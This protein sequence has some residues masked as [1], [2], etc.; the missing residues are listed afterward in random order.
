[1]Y[2]LYLNIVFRDHDDLL[3]HE[4]DDLVGNLFPDVANDIY[5][6]ENNTNDPEATTIQENPDLL[7]PHGTSWSVVQD[8]ISI[9]PAANHLYT[10]QASFN[11]HVQ[12]PPDPRNPQIE[13][14]FY[15]LFPMKFVDE[16]IVPCTNTNLK[17]N[18]RS[19]TSKGEFLKFLGITLAM[20]L[21]PIYGGIETYW[22]SCTA[23]DSTMI[24]R[25][26][27]ARFGMS[28]SRFEC[29]RKALALNIPPA[30]PA[31]ESLLRQSDPWWRVSKFIAAFNANREAT[32]TPGQTL[33]VDELMS[34][35]TGIDSEYDFDALPHSSYEQRKPVPKGTEMK[36]MCDGDSGIMLRVEVLEGKERMKQKEFWRE[37]GTSTACV[38]RMGRAYAGSGRVMCHDAWFT[39]MKCCIANYNINGL[40]TQGI[41]KG[42]HKGFPRQYLIDWWES[43]RNNNPTLRRPVGEWISLYCLHDE[44]G[45]PTPTPVIACGWNDL[46]LKCIIATCGTTVKDP[47]DYCRPR[48]RIE[49]IEGEAEQVK[50]EKLI[51]RPKLV[52]QL[53]KHFG[54][55]DFHDRYRQGELHM[56]KSWKT[57]KWPVRVFT[58][59]L[60]IIFTDCFFG[61][62]YYFSKRPVVADMKHL[63]FKHYLDLLAFRLINNPWMTVRKHRKRKR[64][65]PLV[66]EMMPTTHVLD[67]LSQHDYY[68]QKIQSSDKRARLRC[69]ICSSLCSSYC[70]TCTRHSGNSTVPPNNIVALC[71]SPN[72]TCYQSHILQFN[73]F[74]NSN[75][76][77]S[78]N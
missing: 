50:Y 21:D 48:C 31:A 51:Q 16:V 1:M 65:A 40:F 5:G 39:S 36:A 59:I 42:A 44:N 58:S 23:E 20:A 70:V 13:D 73:N 76:S 45:E 14:F 61:Y 57:K 27:E 74:D 68:K 43:G 25:N 32:I 34:G 69:R 17:K 18:N 8:H 41:L 26:Y 6:H 72:S 75:I 4:N 54:K 38:L 22:R 47:E 67:Y 49:I 10:L 19:E 33:C 29:I 24:G 66:D 55:V 71:N 3:D 35:W 56:E 78:D 7:R 52:G 28:L 12:P 62:R 53:F 63:D 30:T 9:D 15:L 64:N 2:I 77:D 46:A 37:Y 11:W 60:G